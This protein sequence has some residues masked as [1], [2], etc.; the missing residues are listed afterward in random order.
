MFIEGIQRRSKRLWPLAS[1]TPLKIRDMK[2]SSNDGGCR[3]DIQI[4]LS[5]ATYILFHLHIKRK[6]IA[7]DEVKPNK[8]HN[9]GQI[10]PHIKK[11]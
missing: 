4:C 10:K 2:K 1:T 5:G 7:Y 8:K 11:L 6:R 9:R 3:A